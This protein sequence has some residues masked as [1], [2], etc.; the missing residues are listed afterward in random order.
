M[1]GSSP[2]DQRAAVQAVLSHVGVTLA[3]HMRERDERL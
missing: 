2:S 1:A 3:P